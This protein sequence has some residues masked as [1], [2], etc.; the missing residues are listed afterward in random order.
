MYDNKT[1]II[2]YYFYFLKHVYF[3]NHQKHH[4]QSYLQKI[5]LQKLYYEIL[6]IEKNHVYI[7]VQKKHFQKSVSK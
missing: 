4:L 7:F 1:L 2:F 3:Q 5:Y 6:G